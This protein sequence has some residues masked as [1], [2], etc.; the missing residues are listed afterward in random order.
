MTDWRQHLYF[1]CNCP[2]W[3]LLSYSSSISLGGCRAR[4][5]LHIGVCCFKMVGYC[6]WSHWHLDSK[7][8]GIPWVFCAL[9]ELCL[10]WELEQAQVLLLNYLTFECKEC[11]N[12]PSCIHFLCLSDPS[13]SHYVD[14]L[15]VSLV[16]T[17]QDWSLV[18]LRKGHGEATKIES[19]HPH[20]WRLIWSRTL[21]VA[22]QCLPQSSHLCCLEAHLFH[23]KAMSQKN[24]SRDNSK[25]LWVTR[26]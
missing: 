14:S 3:P 9:A 2:I 5:H 1:Y 21:T 22:K 15:F 7:T 24:T 20:D 6:Q 17:A 12:L 10:G 19:K 13:W 26:P 4:L 8:N 23:P 11:P 25:T 18:T 16:A